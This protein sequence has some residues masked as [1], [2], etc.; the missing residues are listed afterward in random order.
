MPRSA[1]S[2]TEKSV[3]A[4]VIRL[5]PELFGADCYWT[6]N[7]PSA[8]GSSG[9]PDIEVIPSEGLFKH[10]Y[11]GI[12]FKAGRYGDNPTAGLTLLQR[13]TLTKIA[14]AGGISIVANET[15]R[16]TED[17]WTWRYWVVQR[18]G[19]VTRGRYCTSQNDLVA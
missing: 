12:E 19:T 4:G 17:G 15:P 11:V 10:R 16:A 14:K 7:P 1:Q 9:R 3:R 13:V 5:L 6:S 18:D 8:H 2:S